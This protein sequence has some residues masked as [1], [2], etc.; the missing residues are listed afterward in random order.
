MTTIDFYCNTNDHCI[1]HNNTILHYINTDYHNNLFYFFYYIF[2]PIFSISFSFLFSFIFISYCIYKPLVNDFI[3]LYNK[4]P[5]LYTFDPFLLEY[6]DEFDKLET[7]KLT[8]NQFKKLKNSFINLTTK[9]GNILMYYD[10]ENQSFNYYAKQSNTFSFNYLDVIS[11]IYVVK[12]N[13]KN[14]YNDNFQNYHLKFNQH[15]N[16]NDDQNDDQNDTQ[17]DNN[18]LDTDIKSKKSSVFYSRTFKTK[19]QLNYKANKYK[20]K[21]TIDYFYKKYKLFN[22]YITHIED[23]YFFNI[24]NNTTDIDLSNI[25]I[26]YNNLNLFNIDISNTYLSNTDLSNTDLS[27]TDLSNIDISN[28]NL[29]NYIFSLNIDIDE[30][31][32]YDEDYI[33]PDNTKEISYSDFI[34]KQN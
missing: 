13:C 31:N 4:N 30:N 11:R 16:Q 20:Y 21:G 10:Y 2:I 34:K 18:Q 23:I 22:R 28:I 19:K 32:F 7:Y 6:I 17:N 9:F 5:D 8:T 15:D 33:I 1:L 29:S 25:D 24:D 14:L 27:N 12:Y 3:K 26:S